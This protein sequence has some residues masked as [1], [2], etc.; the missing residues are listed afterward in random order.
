MEIFLTLLMICSM[1]TSLTTEAIKKLLDEKDKKY[2]ANLLA[3]GI[4]VVLAIGVSIAYLVITSTA[5]TPQIA[6]YI[7]AL[8]LLSFLCATLGYDK[9]MQTIAQLNK[10]RT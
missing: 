1:M 8:V 5:F 10:A 7:I 2:S 9:V 4:S 3:A 6:V